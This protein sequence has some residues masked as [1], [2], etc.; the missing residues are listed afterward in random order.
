MKKKEIFIIELGEKLKII[1]K[2]IMVD[3]IFVKL[4]FYFC[5]YKNF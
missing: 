5:Y 1:K 3:E 2:T 4:S